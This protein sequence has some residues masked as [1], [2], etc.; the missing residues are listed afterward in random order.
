M[1][2]IALSAGK[3]RVGELR[4]QVLLRRLMR[5]VA[6]ETVRIVER[7]SLVDLRERVTLWIV[8][9]QAKRRGVLCKMKVELTLAALPRLMGDMA[10]VATH[11]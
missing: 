7:L 5:V 8:A 4:H 9:V 6:G 3:R 2:G 1:A 11:I 10:S